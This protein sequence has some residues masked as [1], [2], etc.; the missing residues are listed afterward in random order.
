MSASL[1][2]PF[3]ARKSDPPVT[4]GTLTTGDG[5]FLADLVNGTAVLNLNTPAGERRF[6]VA[7]LVHGGRAVGLRATA[8]D[9]GEVVEVTFQGG[10]R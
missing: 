4:A 3:R 8:F 6:W 2:S 1:P 7:F 5:T 10:A 9:T